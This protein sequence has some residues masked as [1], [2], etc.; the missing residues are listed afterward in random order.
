MIKEI[1]PPISYKQLSSNRNNT[2]NNSRRMQEILRASREAK[3]TQLMIE[4]RA[5]IKP[6]TLSAVS[7]AR[8]RLKTRISMR[9]KKSQM[10]SISRAEMTCRFMY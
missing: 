5:I 1:L 2:I 9:L 8:P 6:G 3:Q 7:P 4:N 10:K